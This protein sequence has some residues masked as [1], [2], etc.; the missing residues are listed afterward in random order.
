MSH[1]GWSLRKD[2]KCRTLKKAP[3]A[4][5]SRWPSFLLFF[6]FAFCLFLCL[7]SFPFSVWVFIYLTNSPVLRLTVSL[8][9]AFSSEG[10]TSRNVTWLWLLLNRMHFY[11]RFIEENAHQIHA[12][13][14]ANWLVMDALKGNES[15]GFHWGNLTNLR[16]VL[17]FIWQDAVKKSERCLPFPLLLSLGQV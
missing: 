2:R 5:L 1:C 6:S 8:S 9:S 4:F 7:S 11:W 10:H 13:T 12:H 15:S 16:T 17:S 3:Q 14:S